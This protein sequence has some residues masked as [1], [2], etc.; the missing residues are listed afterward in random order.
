MFWLIGHVSC[1]SRAAHMC[2]N[3]NQTELR[4]AAGDNKVDVRRKRTHSS[5]SNSVNLLRYGKL[6]LMI[7]NSCWEIFPS[8]SVSKFL[9]TDWKTQVVRQ[10]KPMAPTTGGSLDMQRAAN[11]HSGEKQR[12]PT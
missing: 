7:S 12:W 11:A 10:L 6:L 2:V 5:L 1:V 4:E 3:A 9:K 8:P